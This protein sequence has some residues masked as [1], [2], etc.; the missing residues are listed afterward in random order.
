MERF[1]VTILGIAILT[2]VFSYLL[3]GLFYD[4]ETE[5]ISYFFVKDGMRSLAYSLYIIA[6]VSMLGNS[7]L[8]KIFK[9]VC[10]L[11][12][13]YFMIDAFDR[14]VMHSNDLSVWDIPLGIVY[15]LFSIPLIIWKR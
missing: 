1:A 10:L 3:P 7:V 11:M 2:T 9:A 14:I 5:K 6:S 4:Y 15:V 8:K 13:M 12:G